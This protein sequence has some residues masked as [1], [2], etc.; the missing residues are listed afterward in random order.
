MKTKIIFGSGSGSNS[1][2]NP[3]IKTDDALYWYINKDGARVSKINY[4]YFFGDDSSKITREE[5]DYVVFKIIASYHHG[6]SYKELNDNISEYIADYYRINCDIREN[7][8][9]RELLDHFN[10]KKWKAESYCVLSNNCQ[11]FA[12]EI[13]KILKATR[14]DE[15]TKIRLVEKMILPNSLISALWDN[16]DWSL[17]NTIGRIPIIGLIY[18]LIILK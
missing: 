16:E 9:L 15:R 10:D 17:T 6:I 11:S 2:N 14:K 7:M 1:S 18:D 3:R 8:S 5:I 4:E 12:A 13:I